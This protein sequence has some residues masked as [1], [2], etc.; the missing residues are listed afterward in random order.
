MTRRQ[1]HEKLYEIAS[2]H[3]G[4]F[5]ALEA[6]EAGFDRHLIK[7]HVRGGRFARTRRGLYRLKQ[8][9]PTPHEELTAAWMAAGPE[10]VVSHESALRLHGLSDVIP[11]RIHLT[12]PREL[13]WVRRRVPKGV[14]IHTTVRR[15]SQK[16][17]VRRGTVRV[18]SAARSIVDSAEA[19]TGPEQ[20]VAS[21]RQALREDL[22][23]RSRLL[24]AVQGRSQR[25]ADLVK[26]AIEDTAR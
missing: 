4:Y 16:D 21:A 6:R 2:E 11:R 26:R 19:G 24:A 17:V 3:G 25:V 22:T 20:I 8:F 15:L 23:T 1:G 5:T 7:H 18:T 9:P 10:A 12:V 14:L 13:R